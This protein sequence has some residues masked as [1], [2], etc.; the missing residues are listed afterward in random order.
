MNHPANAWRR[1]STAS[2]AARLCCLISLAGVCLGTTGCESLRE[3]RRNQEEQVGITTIRDRERGMTKGELQQQVIRFSKRFIN[4]IIEE[5]PPIFAT[6]D[7]PGDRAAAFYR[8]LTL[9][10]SAIMIASSPYPEIN[11]LDMVVMVTLVRYMLEE[12]WIPEVYGE[13]MRPLLEK[14]KESEADIWNLAQR[15]LNGAQLAEL[16]ALIEQWRRDHPGQKV[17]AYVRLKDFELTHEGGIL[18]EINLPL[19]LFPEVDESTRAMDEMRL[20]SE[21]L[22]YYL[23]TVSGTVRSDAQLLALNLL[24]EPDLA[25]LLE[26]VTLFR[27]ASERFAQSIEQLPENL[28]KETR[29]AL[30]AFTEDLHAEQEILMDE[31]EAQEPRIRSVLADSRETMKTASQVLVL[32][33]ETL[34]T[35]DELRSNFVGADEVSKS[36]APSIPFDINDYRTTAEALERLALQLDAVLDGANDLL[37]STEWEQRVPELLDAM[38]K[39]QLEGERLMNHAFFRGLYLIAISLVGLFLVLIGYNRWRVSP[40][41]T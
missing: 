7:D 24:A 25:Q 11:L 30:D 21:R 2:S 6:L 15:V 8:A 5:T 10:R 32:M 9:Q 41:G 1:L 29:A 36:G 18:K 33:N 19:S 31:F 34:E 26:D 4:N 3:Q 35:V 28:G 17:V 13:L 38:S 14:M 23:Q 22:L 20:A 16:R 39:A 12:Y 40:P 27:Q 37:S